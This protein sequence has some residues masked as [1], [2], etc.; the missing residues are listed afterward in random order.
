MLLRLKTSSIKH[1]GEESSYFISV[2][3]QK[4]PDACGNE[5]FTDVSDSKNIVDNQTINKEY[6]FNRTTAIKSSAMKSSLFEV[7]MLTDPNSIIA[8]QIFTDSSGII[9]SLKASEKKSHVF[10]SVKKA[11][12]ILKNKIY[13]YFNNINAYP[14]LKTTLSNTNDNITLKIIRKKKLLAGQ[15]DVNW[16]RCYEDAKT[17]QAFLVSGSVLLG[18]FKNASLRNCYPSRNRRTKSAFPRFFSWT[19]F[20]RKNRL[21][22]TTRFVTTQPIFTVYTINATRVENFVEYILKESDF[23]VKVSLWFDKIQDHS[24]VTNNSSSNYNNST[25]TE[26]CFSVTGRVD[27]VES[28][29]NVAVNAWLPQVSYPCGDFSTLRLRQGLSSCVE[30]TGSSS[31]PAPT[32]TTT[33]TTATST[34]EN[35]DME[36]DSS[37]GSYDEGEEARVTIGLIPKVHQDLPAGFNI[38]DHHCHKY[39]LNLLAIVNKQNLH[40]SCNLQKVMSLYH[41][42]LQYVYISFDQHKSNFT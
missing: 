27:I 31:A 37:Y 33:T 38:T 34:T 15:D 5:N 19:T 39:K 10:L 7:I 1:E 22:A 20:E 14:Q 12:C 8:L 3:I 36:E 29:S 40:I 28:K 4:I 30:D 9:I 35:Q 23:E 21:Q 32:T 25:F 16:E 2:N 11:K 41:I 26:F 13:N 17:K 24:L 18:G 42:M 6:A